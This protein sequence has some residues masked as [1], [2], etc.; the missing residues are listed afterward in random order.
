[1]YDAGKIIS[2]II[3]FII[4][5]TIPIWYNRVIGKMLYTPELKIVTKEKNCIESKEYMRD[6]HMQLLDNWRTMVVR[7]GKERIHIS[8]L[9]NKK[10][11]ISLTNT[12]I[13]CHSNK[14]DFCDKCH[15]YLMVSPKCWDC[16]I[17]PEEKKI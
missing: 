6:S 14:K 9:D 17:I 8:Q 3:I 13:K 16:H 5:L 7:E 11:E 2:G 1:M 10:H 12:C 15:D 4:I